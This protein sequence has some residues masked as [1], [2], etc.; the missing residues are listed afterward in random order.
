MN[1]QGW[2]RDEVDSPCVRICVL[3][4][5]DRVCLGCYRTIDEISRWSAMSSEERGAVI[6]ALPGRK[7]VDRRRG[8]RAG[9]IAR[10]E[11]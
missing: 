1:D 9:R 6:A 7:P 4:P 11:G 2:S 3:H 10:G 8:G 5:V